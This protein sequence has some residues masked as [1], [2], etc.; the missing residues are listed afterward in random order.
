MDYEIQLIGRII[1]LDKKQ[2]LVLYCQQVMH[3]KY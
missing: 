3:F 1:S 2:A